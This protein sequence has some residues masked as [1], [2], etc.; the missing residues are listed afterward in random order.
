[1]FRGYSNQDLYSFYSNWV[2]RHLKILKDFKKST[3]GYPW[4]M[5]AKQWD[6]ILDEMINH[7]EMMNED[8][9]AESLSKGMPETYK[10]DYKAVWEIMERHRE[11]FFKLFS[12][13]FYNLWY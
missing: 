12:K 13:Y 8:R 9:V 11:E 10:V 2:E 7:L 6:E 3:V 4:N 5:T 1:M